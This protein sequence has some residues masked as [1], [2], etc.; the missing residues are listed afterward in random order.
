MLEAGPGKPKP[1]GEIEPSSDAGTDASIEQRLQEDPENREARLDRA[2]DESMDASDPPAATQPVHQH[3]IPESSGYDPKKEA[4]I[5]A[6][7][8]KGLFGRIAA[9]L[10]LG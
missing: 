5:A 9:K 3:H 7:K 2:L 6:A 4:G 8:G 1:G 10:G